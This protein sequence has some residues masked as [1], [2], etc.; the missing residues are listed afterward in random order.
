MCMAKDLFWS[1]VLTFCL[2][3]RKNCHSWKVEEKNGMGAIS[4]L[5]FIS[6]DTK[7]DHQIYK[8]QKWIQ[9]IQIKSLFIHMFLLFSFYF[10]WVIFFYFWLQV[11]KA[12]P[13]FSFLLHRTKAE[14]RQ[15]LVNKSHTNIFSL[16]WKKI[17]FKIVSK[18]LFQRISEIWSY[19]F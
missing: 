8:I 6:V 7:N 14:E 1:S 9:F 2:K 12:P 16:S 18:I 17:V 11:S 5:S 19:F 10:E 13:F 4:S 3:N 15:K